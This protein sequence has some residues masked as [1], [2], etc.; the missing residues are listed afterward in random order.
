MKNTQPVLERPQPRLFGLA[1]LLSLGGL[2]D[3]IYLTV[4]HLTG[5]DVTCIASSGCSEVLSSAYSSVGKIPLGA[6]GALGYFVAFSLATLAAFGYPRARIFLTVVVA[7]MLATTLWLLYVQ[8]FVLHAFCDFCL[9]SAALTLSLSVIVVV[10]YF[11][12]RRHRT[13]GEEAPLLE[14]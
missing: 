5:E 7:G 9:L 11:T 13:A 4:T 10:N 1:A 3:S 14:S 8:A 2:A 6:F 12:R